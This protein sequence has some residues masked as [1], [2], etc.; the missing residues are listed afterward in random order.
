MLTQFCSSYIAGICHPVLN[1][2]PL[3]SCQI[4]Y[5]FLCHT[6]TS[7]KVKTAAYCTPDIGLSY[8]FAP[9]SLPSSLSSSPSLPSSLPSVLSSP[10]S[11]STAKVTSCFS[12]YLELR[13]CRPKLERVKHILL[14]NPFCGVEGEESSVDSGQKVQGVSPASLTSYWASMRL[15]SGWLESQTS[16]VLVW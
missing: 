2:E 12:H 13:P 1:K 5:E 4:L 3:Q 11:P 6:L 15:Q 16:G 8:T 14:E 9:L 10:F 7:T